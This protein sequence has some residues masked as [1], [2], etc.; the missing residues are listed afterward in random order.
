MMI[1]AGVIQ[2]QPTHSLV[3]SWTVDLH[4]PSGKHD[5]F[6]FYKDGRLVGRRLDRYGTHEVLGTYRAKDGKL[7]ITTHKQYL[8]GVLNPP[9]YKVSTKT[10]PMKWKSRDSFVWV[11]DT[12]HAALFRRRKA[13]K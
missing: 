7:T 9:S 13:G 12:K 4:A 8:N 10:L 2:A 3:G 11:F 5:V 6:T 1:L